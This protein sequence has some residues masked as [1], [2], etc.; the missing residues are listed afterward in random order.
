[1]PRPRS[2]NPS[3]EAIRKREARARERDGITVVR[4]PVGQAFKDALAEFGLLAMGDQ[5][6][7][8]KLAE[9]VAEACRE[10]IG[11]GP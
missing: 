4:L 11:I 6:D 3:P 8:D 9:A 2:A 5:D 7:P 10:W 1:M